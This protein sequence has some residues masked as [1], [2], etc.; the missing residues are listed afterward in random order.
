MQAVSKVVKKL[1]CSWLVENNKAPLHI[2]WRLHRR[3]QPENGLKWQHNDIFSDAGMYRSF[4]ML[5][6]NSNTKFSLIEE[7][8]RV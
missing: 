3:F 6:Y 2:S 1:R 8:T 7:L 4:Y 5:K